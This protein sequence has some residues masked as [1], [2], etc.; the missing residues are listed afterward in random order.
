MDR[1]QAR[2]GGRPLNPDEVAAF[3]N[4]YRDRFHVAAPTLPSDTPEQLAAKTAADNSNWDNFAVSTADTLA[5]AGTGL[6]GIVAPGT[7]ADMHREQAQAY[8]SRPGVS[9]TAG[10]VAGFTIQFLP[11]VLSG[12]ATAGPTVFGFSAAAVNSATIAGTAASTFGN[13]RAEIELYRQQTGIQVPLENELAAASANAAVDYFTQRFGMKLTH[14]GAERMAAKYLPQLAA[15][16]AAKDT[17]EVAR[18]LLRMGAEEGAKEVAGNAA[19]GATS[20]IAKN[21]VDHFTYDPKRRLTE[22][23]G[24]AA[25]EGGAGAAV[26]APLGALN[27]YAAARQ[28]AAGIPVAQPPA[29]APDPLGPPAPAEQPPVAPQLPPVEPPAAPV[30]PQPPAEPPAATPPVAEPPPAP[31]QP[32][33]PPTGLPRPPLPEVPLEQV[34]RPPSITGNPDVDRALIALAHAIQGKPA[35]NVRG[36]L[37]SPETATVGPEGTIKLNEGHGPLPA[38]EHAAELTRQ[39]VGELEQAYYANERDRQADILRTIRNAALEHRV[40]PAELRRH[41]LYEPVPFAENP[42]DNLTGL[43]AFRAKLAEQKGLTPPEP[44]P[45]EPAPERPQ[46]RPPANLKEA[47]ALRKTWRQTYPEAAAAVDAKVQEYLDGAS[48]HR[49]YE[50]AVSHSDNTFVV[51]W[52]FENGKKVEAGSVHADSFDPNTGKFLGRGINPGKFTTLERLSPP[53]H[54]EVPIQPGGIRDTSGTPRGP[55]DP[56]IAQF[57]GAQ[58]KHGTLRVQKINDRYFAEVRKKPKDMPQSILNGADEEIARRELARIVT[59]PPPGPPP[60]APMREKPAA[61]LVTPGSLTEPTPNDSPAMRQWKTFKQQYPDYLM[62]FRMGDFYEAFHQD[63]E[64]LHKVAGV[65]LTKRGDVA[66]AGVPFHAVEGYMRK[67]IAAG[68]KVA[69]AELDANAPKGIVQREVIKVSDGESRGFKRGDVLE[70]TG[71]SGKEAAKGAKFTVIEEHPD[72]NAIVVEPLEGGKSLTLDPREAG[73]YFQKVDKFNLPEPEPQKPAEV[74]TL[75][76]GDR[77]SY[78]WDGGKSE[79]T[80]LVGPFDSGV[81]SE[82]NYRIKWESGPLAEKHKG[83]GFADYRVQDLQK[84]EPPAAPPKNLNEAKARRTKAAPPPAP[85]PERTPSGLPSLDT[86]KIEKPPADKSLAGKLAKGTR[87]PGSLADHRAGRP[88]ADERA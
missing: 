44:T 47:N 75:N 55:I 77:V 54:H 73:R 34:N 65:A 27:R 85:E 28:L 64:T 3:T 78:V 53:P 70:Y 17:P 46:L 68:H 41:V 50:V 49:P 31:T 21:A 26:L 67:L 16:I 62:L 40:D 22:G 32:P 79:G 72:R 10:H 1:Y 87:R 6:V 71:E 29:K 86:V 43:D 76:K 56:V 58:T 24:Q 15:R 59:A 66:M 48:Y 14:L 80:V 7:A 25:I 36:L 88:K 74:P 2:M 42:A 84:I 51:K 61:K 69:I 30:V 52:T 4:A 20:Q 38:L 63:A 12:G 37:P 11:A 57:D 82:P 45:E 13:K 35:E 81:K 19:L 39:K 9:Q 8:A 33:G 18:I 5:K 23:A 60:Q 83:L